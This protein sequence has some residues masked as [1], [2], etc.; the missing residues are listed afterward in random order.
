EARALAV[1]AIGLLEGAAVTDDDK[2]V[3]ADAFRYHDIAASEL[4]GDDGMLHLDRALALYDEVGDEL[5]M[6]KVLSL[7]GVRAY[8]RGDWTEAA[9]LYGRA[10]DAADAGGDVV[11]AA[12]E[13]ANAAEILIDQGRTGEA[14]P[15]IKSALRVFTA[16]DNSYL[17]AFVTGFAGRAAM[18]DGDADAA[19][20]AFA[21]AAARFAALDEDDSAMDVRVRGIEADLERGEAERARATIAELSGRGDVQGPVRSRLL[22]LSARVAAADGDTEGAAALARDAAEVPGATPFERALCL[23]ELATV[24]GSPVPRAAA[25]SILA[26]LGVTDIPLPLSSPTTPI[27]SEVPIP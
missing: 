7:G 14:R 22:R 19:A 5:S 3:L 23:A 11:G 4:E 2:R 13:S 10:K 18:R 8:Y 16:S 15:L 6:S 26:D 21:D 9:D 17:V 27:P 1:E 20:A 25:E 12:I 24:T